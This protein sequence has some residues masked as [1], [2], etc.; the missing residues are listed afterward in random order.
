MDKVHKPTMNWAATD[1]NKEWK[2]FK[3]HC[4]FT[5]K[6]PLATK[7]EVEKVNYMMTYIGDKG[8]EVYGTFTWARAEGDRPAENET[9]NGVYAKFDAYVAPKKNTIRATVNFHRRKQLE[10]ERFD[11]FVTDLRVLVKDCNYQ[12][13]DRMLRD[14]IVCNALHSKV[15]E[16]CIDLGDEL[17]LDKAITIGQNYETSQES[18]KVIINKDEDAKIHEVR[19]R[20]NYKQR[21]KQ[22][23]KTSAR[24]NKC[25]KCGYDNTHNKCPAKGKTCA[26]CHKL[27][28]FAAVCRKKGTN[29]KGAHQVEEQYAETDS[30][31]ESQDEYQH[32][33]DVINA[34]GKTSNSEWHET[35]IVDGEPV[36]IQI[37][38]GA[39]A[40]IMSYSWVKNKK[41]NHKLKPTS[42]KLQSYT[43][44]ALEVKGCITLPTTYKKCTVDIMYYVV[45]TDKIPILSGA[46]S[47][48]LQLI[49]R[50]NSINDYPQL[51]KTTGTLPGK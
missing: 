28:H 5:F 30:D 24:N 22:Y 48:Q 2:R 3:Q 16:K 26:V 46:A 23:N 21:P 37:D 35:V 11:D 42:L 9:L 40:S 6:G 43:S 50:I 12:E 20:S 39:A 51:R 13:E 4:E 38:T 44:H 19:K 17:T 47:K 29:P 41:L 34:I 1:L 14:S 32:L 10:G 36:R 15:K 18:M 45:K 33:I 7:S 31:T 27:N 25:T 8:R 49:Q